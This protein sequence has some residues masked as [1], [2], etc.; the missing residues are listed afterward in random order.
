MIDWEKWETVP[1]W[2]NRAE[3]E[4]LYDIAYSMPCPSRIVEIGAY[5]GRSTV[6]L[7]QACRDAMVQKTVRARCKMDVE[8]VDNFSGTGQEHGQPTE[9]QQADGVMM[10]HWNLEMMG[11]RPNILNPS[12]GVYVGSSAQWFAGH[13]DDKYNMFFI[14]GCHLTAGEDVLAAWNR[15]EPGGVLV[16]HDYDPSSPTSKVVMDINA[17]GIPGKHCGVGGTSLWKAIKS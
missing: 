2:F 8:S 5:R 14:D 9:I 3:A 17:T 16:C 11:L 13:P 7:V 4:T 6:I 1:G 12:W 10:L 15:L